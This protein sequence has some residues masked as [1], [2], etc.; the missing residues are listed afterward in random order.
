MCGYNVQVFATGSGRHGALGNG[1]IN[2]TSEPVLVLLRGNFRMVKEL[3]FS[4]NI[5][6]SYACRLLEGSTQDMQ[7]QLMGICMHG[8]AMRNVKLEMVI[9]MINIVLF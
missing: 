3:D 1:D 7:S 8:G 2:S 5:F 4:M 6:L 9:V